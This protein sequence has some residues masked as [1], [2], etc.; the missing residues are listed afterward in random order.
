MTEAAMARHVPVL[1]QEVLD[2]LRPAAG[3]VYVDATLGL[4]GHSRAMLAA[5]APDGRV[6]GFEWDG[7]AVA[8]AGERLASFGE[9]IQIVPTSYTELPAVLHRLGI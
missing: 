2:W 7:Q 9:R 6:I 8:I 4:G 1:L 3:R 5:S